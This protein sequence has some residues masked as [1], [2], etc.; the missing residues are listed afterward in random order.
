MQPRILEEI[1]RFGW[2][3]VELADL[4]LTFA[5]PDSPVF[6]RPPGLYR[7]TLLA[8]APQLSTS[9]TG[10]Y[11]IA[12]EGSN[13]GDPTNDNEWNL[14]ATLAGSNEFF[15]PIGIAVERRLFGAVVPRVM[16][17]VDPEPIRGEGLIPIG[18]YRYLRI[19]T[20]VT[21]GTVTNYRLNV[22]FTGI[23]GDAEKMIRQV[24]VNKISGDPVGPTPPIFLD[25]SDEIQRPAGTRY[26]TVQALVDSL[27]LSPVPSEGFELTL[28]GSIVREPEADDWLVMDIIPSDKL[29][30]VD[31]PPGPAQAYFF[32]QGQTDII[33]M[34]PFQV[35]RVRLLAAP[36]DVDPVV[37]EFSSI[38]STITFTFDD[39]DWLSG[40]IGLTALAESLQ[41][42]FV[43]GS[44]YDQSEAAGTVTIRFQ[45]LDMNDNP[46][47]GQRV[48]G[49]V[50][51]D[52]VWGSTGVP[53]AT[54]TFDTIADVETPPAGAPGAAV[55]FGTFPGPILVIRT[56][57]SGQAELTMTSAASPDTVYVSAFNVIPDPQRA[58]DGQEFSPGQ[59]VIASEREEVNF[60]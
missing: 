7:A 45:I 56:D 29:F 42:T 41:E 3:Q 46:L 34:G 11:S 17:G 51:T 49:I 5:S 18:R 60:P 44:W 26:M 30:D 1:P 13:T 54:A 43:I 22:N 32:T 23:A 12:L 24:T 50:V 48:I 59:V 53:S 14:I 35:F 47:R 6:E 52:T 19:R 39:V 20:F 58:E 16:I 36:A 9:G 38:L 21:S 25:T 27:V 33:D 15:A 4:V 55:L 37:D 2:Q 8:T 40:D 57:Q 31:V 10:T 28:E